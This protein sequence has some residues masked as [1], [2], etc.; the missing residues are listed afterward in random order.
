MLTASRRASRIETF[1]ATL[2]DEQKARI[3]GGGSRRWG[4]ARL[5]RIKRGFHL[6]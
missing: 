1:Y 3:N 4:L 2:N 5:T 6:T